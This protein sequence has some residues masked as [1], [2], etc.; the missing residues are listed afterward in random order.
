MHAFGSVVPNAFKYLIPDSLLI[1][2]N[3]YFKDRGYITNIALYLCGSDIEMI[4][5]QLLIIP[6][7]YMLSVKIKCKFLKEFYKKVHF[8]M[9]IRTTIVMYVRIMMALMINIA[10]PT[11]STLIEIVN[12]IIS[13]IL[14]V[15]FTII[16]SFISILFGWGYEYIS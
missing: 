16:P 13:L 14:F 1:Q 10:N 15:L 9:V 6:I 11:I 4:L 3:K 5:I 12:F 8:N 2:K 7:I